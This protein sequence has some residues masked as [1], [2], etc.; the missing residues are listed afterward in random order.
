VSVISVPLSG[1]QAQ[2]LYF[3]AGVTLASGPGAFYWF[4]V[5]APSDYTSTVLRLAFYD[6][7]SGDVLARNT[8]ILAPPS[9]L[10]LQPVDV[11]CTVNQ[12]PNNDATVDISCNKT[13]AAP[14]LWVT[15]TTLA[16][17]RFSENVFFMADSVLTLQ[18]I[19]FGPLDTALLTRSLRVEHANGYA[20]SSSGKKVEAVAAMM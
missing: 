17:G 1:G 11:A 18:F 2:A 9:K 7:V 12:Q 13:V 16:Q 6:D 20:K 4:N 15:L 14:A 3:K 5:P 19:P 10:Q 8:I